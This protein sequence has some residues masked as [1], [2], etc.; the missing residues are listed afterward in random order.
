MVETVVSAPRIRGYRH[1]NNSLLSQGDI[2]PCRADCLCALSIAYMNSEL[3]DRVARRVDRKGKV[4]PE[5]P[6]MPCGP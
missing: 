3:T 2:V 6:R 4:L 1:G 5:G